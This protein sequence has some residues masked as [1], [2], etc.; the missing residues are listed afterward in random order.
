MK[1]SYLAAFT[2]SASLVTGCAGMQPISEADKTIERVVEAPNYSKDQIFS[3]TKI[4]VAENFK[5]AKSVI[6]YENKEEGT[7]IGNGV[8]AYPCSGMDCLAKSDWK[9]P[10][11]MRV[12]MKN[13][14]FKLT[15]T[16]MQL[17]WPASV[18]GATYTRANDGSPIYYQ[19]DID[20]IK[21]A[22]LKFGYELQASMNNNKKS[23]NW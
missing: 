4:W 8:I 7:I 10:F 14:K 20:K 12:D 16:N 6:E 18:S 19:G 2:V 17:A 23:S 3:A 9:V 15:F 11:T 22:L 13:E 21:P 1:T 5:S